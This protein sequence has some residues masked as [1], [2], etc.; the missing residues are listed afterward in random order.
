MPT[1]DAGAV[2]SLPELSIVIPTFNEERIVE[3]SVARM[4]P[5]IRGG[6]SFEVIFSDDGSADQTPAILRRLARSHTEIRVVG[7][8]RN[9]GKGAAIKAGVLASRGRFVLYTD[10]DLVYGVDQVDAY[11]AALAG[12]A[13]L[14]IGSRGHPD[15]RFVLH[16]RHFPYL[17]LRHRI[18]V[19]YI[20]LVNRLLGLGVSDTQ[21]GFKM[22]RGDVAR[23]LFSETRIEDF[24]FDVELLCLARMR[25]FKIVE[26]PVQLRYRGSPSSVRLMTDAPRM[27]LDLLAIRMRIGGAR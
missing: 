22:I 3:E 11:R 25:G 14:A 6:G 17:S 24:A 9:R 27:I 21:C 4:L 12:G 20:A 1:E 15:T 2:D 23:E 16:P 8:E 19:T 5:A 18:G 26:L 10:A 13:D 7:H